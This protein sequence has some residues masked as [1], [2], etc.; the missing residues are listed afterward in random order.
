MTG[1]Y[2]SPED[3]CELTNDQIYLRYQDTA[4]VIFKEHRNVQNIT[5]FLTFGNS[6][7]TLVYSNNGNQPII[8]RRPFEVNERSNRNLKSQ[9]LTIYYRSSKNCTIS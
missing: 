3:N 9:L 2:V 1:N 6:R 7:K 4:L 8:L 5:N